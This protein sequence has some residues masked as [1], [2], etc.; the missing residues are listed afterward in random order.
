MTVRGDCLVSQMISLS[1]FFMGRSSGGNSTVVSLLFQSVQGCSSL[2]MCQNSRTVHMDFWQF[3]ALRCFVWIFLGKLELLFR[4]LSFDIS[5]W[6]IL[7][8]LEWSTSTLSVWKGKQF[9]LEHIHMRASRI[10]LWSAQAKGNEHCVLHCVQ[11][12]L[13]WEDPRLLQPEPA[14]RGD[15][16][17]LCR[18]GK[19][20]SFCFI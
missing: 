14:D 8:R 20:S 5:A 17:A 12:G 16:Q 3:L 11:T 1:K 15:D 19:W 10:S 7:Y 9:R 6:A 13:L 18:A 4:V 2:G